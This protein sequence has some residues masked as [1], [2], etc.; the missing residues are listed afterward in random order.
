MDHAT[1][2]AGAAR[3]LHPKGHVIDGQV[4]PPT[5][6]ATLPVEDPATGEI[7]AHIP[8]GD[9]EDIDR[10]VGRRARASS[11]GR[12]RAPIRR[13]AGGCCGRS[14]GRS[15]RRRRRWRG[16][17]TR[18]SGKPIAEARADITGTAEILEYYAGLASQIAGQTMRA[19]GNNYA[20]VS[21]AHWER[22]AKPTPACRSPIAAMSRACIRWSSGWSVTCGATRA[23]R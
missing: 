16:S 22:C 19:P 3:F 6:G 11:R 12:G 21:R 7:F 2:P 20:M 1:I 23:P 5:R 9:A 14:R 17:E 4:V 18:D 8:A 13:T 15:A 10:A